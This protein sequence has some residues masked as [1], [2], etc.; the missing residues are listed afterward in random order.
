ML[1]QVKS[2]TGTS[3][4]HA[5]HAL[6]G[7]YVMFFEGD[8]P[9]LFTDNETN[10]QRLFPEF[11]NPGPYVKDGINN[12]VVMGRRDEVNPMGVGTKMAAHTRRLIDPGQSVTMRLR[13]TAQLPERGGGTQ[14]DVNPFGPR[15]DATLAGRQREADEFVL[16]RD[17]PFLISREAGHGEEV[18]PLPWMLWS[19]QCSFLRRQPMADG[20]SVPTPCRPP[21]ASLRNRDWFHMQNEDIISMPGQVG[22]PVVCGAGPGLLTRWPLSVVDPDFAK[23]QVELMLR[24]SLLASQTARGP[25]MRGTFS[26]VNLPVHAFVTVLALYAMVRCARRVRPR[27]PEVGLQ[28]A[29]AELHVVGR[30]ARTVAAR[31]CLREGSS[32]S[33]TSVIFD[34]SMRRLPTGVASGAGADGTAWM[35]L[36]S[37]NMLELAVELG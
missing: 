14:I 19:K 6:L 8:V 34:R 31:M 15:F 16:L 36:F 33:T 3:A 4:V 35:A 20:A 37:Q 32:A 28:Q 29:A 9:L 5:M 22:V 12:Y 18:R 21:A 7:D 1:R 30:I 23:Q 24:G 13:L 11:P 27:V 25:P 26:D 17:A 10:N 2:P